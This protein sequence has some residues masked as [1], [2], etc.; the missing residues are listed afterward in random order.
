V[1][2]TGIIQGTATVPAGATTGTVA[3]TTPTGTL[4]S[5]PV[6]QVLK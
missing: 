3:V 1:N 5:N 2:P 6:F 4:T